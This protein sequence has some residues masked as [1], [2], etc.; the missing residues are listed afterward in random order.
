MRSFFFFLFFFF[1]CPRF[2][3]GSPCQLDSPGNGC[4]VTQGDSRKGHR[5]PSHADQPTAYDVQPT[6]YS[7]SFPVHGGGGTHGAT[8]GRMT[9]C[10]RE[11]GDGGWETGDGGWGAAHSII[12]GCFHIYYSLLSSRRLGDSQ[13]CTRF[14]S[15]M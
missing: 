6:A 5:D 15:N 10:G 3:P 14:E 11:M 2:L 7:Y 12:H 13:R 4:N 1:C 8:R 9:E